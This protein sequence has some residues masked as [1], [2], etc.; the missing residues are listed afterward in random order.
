MRSLVRPSDGTELIGAG[1][2]RHGSSGI[3]APPRKLRDATGDAFVPGVALYLGER[4]YTFE[5]R[6]HV[7]P[8]DR[9]RAS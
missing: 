3:R 7:M 9:L 6:P 2:H 1:R 5:D 4:S 8:V